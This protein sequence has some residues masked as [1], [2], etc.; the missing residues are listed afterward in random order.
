MLYII[1]VT[2]VIP[3]KKNYSYL[4]LNDQG[5]VNNPA[6]ESTAFGAYYFDTRVLSNYHWALDG[7]SLLHSEAIGSSIIKQH[8]SLFEKH[9]QSLMI[10]RTLQV[11]E[12]G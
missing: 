10:V 11:Q 3:L 7:F 9:K 1:K 8:L 12:N 6:D 4:V 5:L 2:T